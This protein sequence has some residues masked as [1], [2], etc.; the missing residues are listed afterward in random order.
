MGK[1]ILFIDERSSFVVKG[2]SQ[3]FARDGYE[4]KV[5]SLNVND[6]KESGPI[7]EYV[8]ICVYEDS[9]EQLDKYKALK[10][11]CIGGNRKLF[12][13]GFEED[14]DRV[15]PVFPDNMVTT[16][17]KRPANAAMVADNLRDV[18]ENGFGKTKKK[19]ILLVDDSGTLL[20][21]MK[22]WLKDDYRVSMANSAVNAL[23]FMASNI[24]DLILL[25]YEMPVCNGPQLY[26]MLRDEPK[27]KD[28]PIFFLTGVENQEIMD[29]TLGLSPDGYL[30]KSM[31]RE[32]ILSQI[33]AFF[34]MR[35]E[36]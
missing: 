5:V 35:E 6:I 7:P 11:L 23:F 3:N 27:T 31:S 8:F 17:F 22:E 36:S 13:L 32:G 29:V 28:I 19:H 12:F 9:L 15:V 16:A 33:E 1:E 21:A 4:C 34:E 20:N 26:K 30:L 18:I 10:E 25:D 14:L 2:I 24:P